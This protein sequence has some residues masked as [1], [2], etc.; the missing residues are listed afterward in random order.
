MVSI[1]RRGLC[2]GSGQFFYRF[3]VLTSRSD[4]FISKS[5]DLSL[6]H[7]HRVLTGL[8]TVVTP[9]IIALLKEYY[10]M[11]LDANH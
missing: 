6:A 2:H 9:I 7:V 10:V 3:V 8:V 5:S 4:A 11:I 1:D